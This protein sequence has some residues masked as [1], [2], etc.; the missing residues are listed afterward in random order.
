MH[1]Q[2]A[3][4]SLLWSMLGSAAPGNTKPQAIYN[5]IYCHLIDNEGSVFK[6][7]DGQ[8][9]AFLPDGSYAAGSPAGITFYN[10]NG[11]IRWHRKMNVHHQLNLN[12]AGDKL[13]VLSTTVNKFRGKFA[14]F[15][16]LV[17]LGLDGKEQMSYDFYEHRA[18]FMKLAPRRPD[19]ILVKLEYRD[20][21]LPKET[22]WEFSHANSFYEIP[23]N[24]AASKNP[25]FAKGNFI[26]NGLGRHTI[27]VLD[28]SLKK[29]LWSR[30]MNGQFKH[31]VQ[32][33]ESGKLLLY[34]NENTDPANGK[35]YSAIHELDPI[36]GEMTVLYK[37]DPPESFNSLR[38]GGVQR[39]PNQNL[40]ISDV[41]NGGRALEINGAGKVV[42]SMDYPIIDPKTGKPAEIQQVKRLDLTDFLKNHRGL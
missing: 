33:Q 14:R 38:L 22:E 21:A 40:L 15:D 23:D 30:S 7:F 31:D 26:V 18:L 35:N 1:T 6:K 9:C 37:A 8:Y 11:T 34:S 29:I 13:L 25:A 39:L 12:S 19:R 28:K 3:L 17:V 20:P 16:K 5:E 42:W 32:M 2:M 41:T 27:S 10:A 24:A 4:L 36:T